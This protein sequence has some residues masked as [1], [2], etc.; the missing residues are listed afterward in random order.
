MTPRE[1]FESYM[2]RPV[3]SF[4]EAER[5]DIG[6]LIMSGRLSWGERRALASLFGDYDKS[7]RVVRRFFRGLAIAFAL[8]VALTIA[9]ASHPTRAR[10]RGETLGK[11]IYRVVA[12]INVPPTIAECEKFFDHPELFVTPAK[13][14]NGSPVVQPTPKNDFVNLKKGEVL[15]FLKPAT[16][17]HGFILARRSNGQKVCVTTGTVDLIPQPSRTN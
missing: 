8:L 16:V 1:R 14:V 3:S 17:P 7:E 12:N 6:A 10:A 11:T 2:R 5:A 4:T 15:T 9:F 13:N